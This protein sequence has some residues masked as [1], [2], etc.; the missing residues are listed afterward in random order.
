MIEA[1]K[2]VQEGGLGKIQ[3]V[4]GLCY[5]RRDTIGKVE[6]AQTLPKSVE[7]DLWCGPARMLPLTRKNLHYDW[8]WVWETGNGDLGNQGIHQM[9]IARWILGENKLSPAV[10]SVGGRFGYDDDGQTPNTLLT[11]HDYKPAPLIFEVRGLP[12]KPGAKEMNEYKGAQVG[13]V[14]KCDGGNLVLTSYHGGHAEDNEGKK[15]R[16]FKGEGDHFKNFIEAVLN[17]KQESLHAPIY[18]G[19]ISSGLCHTSNISYR[20]GAATPQDQIREKLRSNSDALETFESINMH[21]QTNLVDL[22]K[23]KAILGEF[24]TFNPDSESFNGNMEA[25]KLLKRE[26][27]A[28]FVIPE[29]V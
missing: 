21:L 23:T 19:H 17:R 20:L 15:I 9:D 4:R 27:R 2:Y 12:E 13:V 26:C 6:G 22:N 8:H 7:Y 5:K 28:P 1:V 24:L 3:H 25:N 16:D 18:E 14:V 11:Y 29:K 10:F